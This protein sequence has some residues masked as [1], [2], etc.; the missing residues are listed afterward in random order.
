MRSAGRPAGPC[1]LDALRR[2]CRHWHPKSAQPQQIWSASVTAAG[3]APTFFRT[4]WPRRWPGSAAAW[5]TRSGRTVTGS[6]PGRDALDLL[7]RPLSRAVGIRRRRDVLHLFASTTSDG[8]WSGWAER[9]ARRRRHPTVLTESEGPERWPHLSLRSARSRLRP[10]AAC[11]VCSLA[12]LVPRGNDRP[13]NWILD[14]ELSVAIARAPP[15]IG[16]RCATAL[17]PSQGAA[18]W[19][20]IWDALGTPLADDNDAPCTRAKTPTSRP[21]QLQ[22]AWR[23]AAVNSVAPMACWPPAAVWTHSRPG[24]VAEALA[25]WRRQFSN[26]CWRVDRAAPDTPPSSDR[27]GAAPLDG[28]AMDAKGWRWRIRRKLAAT[29]WGE[30]TGR[31]ATFAS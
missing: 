31:G 16:A 10:S 17:Q 19:P 20:R 3:G 5:A 27:L 2:S 22:D 28:C 12:R 1:I 23:R 7:R 9:M 4:S 26:R 6:Q 13:R 25:G 30:L 18:S 29:F 11:C 15:A 14:N 8:S 24:P 21:A